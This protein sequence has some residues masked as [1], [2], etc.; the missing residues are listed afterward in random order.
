[1]K[2]VSKLSL[3]FLFLLGNLTLCAYKITIVG[4]GYVGLTLAS[5][6]LNNGHTLECIDV[7]EI[8]I[9]ALN[10]KTLPIY[11]TNLHDSLFNS[12]YSKNISFTQNINNTTNTEIYYLCVPTPTDASGACNC[13]YLYAAFDEIVKNCNTTDATVI[14]IKSTVPPGTIRTLLPRIPDNKKTTTHVIYNPE[15][16]REGCAIQDIYNNPIILGTESAYAMQKI[17]NL[18]TAFLPSKINIIRTTFETAEIIKYAWNSFSAIRIAYVNELASFCKLYNADSAAVMLGL[19]LN[20]KFLPTGSIKPGPGYGGSCL[21]KD[22]TSFAQIMEKNKLFHSIISQTIKSNKEH[23]KRII[24]NILECLPPSD[25]QTV[26]LLGLSFKANTNDIR[27][28][29]SIDI[30]Q[31]LLDQG[32][33]VKAYDPQAIADMKKLF[34]TVHYF[35]SPYEAIKNSDCLVILTEWQEIKELDLNKVASLCNRKIIVDT[36]NIYDK[37]QLKHYNFKY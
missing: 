30:I 24:A 11:E 1:M 28:A 31:A 29:P 9:L 33:L 26:T 8:K 17:E 23:K 2:I 20:E 35:D 27:S 25:L 36:R 32:I 18:Y 21:P 15:F 19:A 3:A 6:L 37:D 7:D 16:M 14:C 4:C 22:T 13:S 34:P 12:T 5:I 10:N